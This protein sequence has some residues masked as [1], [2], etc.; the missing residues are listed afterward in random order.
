MLTGLA[1]S[2]ESAGLTDMTAPGRLYGTPLYWPREQITH[3][4]Y[5]A[6]ATDV[7]S[8]GAVFY[9]MLTGDWARDGFKEMFQNCQRRRRAAGMPEIMGVIVTNPIAPLQQRNPPSPGAWPR[10]S[11]GLCR[12][13]G[14]GG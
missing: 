5:L 7:F 4:K 1:K 13:R 6:P 12:G 9:E 14:A 3:Y 8:I 2:F 10:S 11:T